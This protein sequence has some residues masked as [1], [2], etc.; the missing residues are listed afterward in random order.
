MHF[1]EKCWFFCEEAIILICWFTAN[2]GRHSNFENE[3]QD[4][5]W[6]DVGLNTFICFVRCFISYFRCHVLFSSLEFWDVL[7]N[8]GCESEVAELELVVIANKYVLKFYVQVCI[9][10]LCV[11]MFKCTT[12]LA[13][14][15]FEEIFVFDWSF[16]KNY[17]KQVSFA[18][19]HS[20]ITG[21]FLFCTTLT[22][23]CEGVIFVVRNFT[24]NLDLAILL[25]KAIC[26]QNIRVVVA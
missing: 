3:Q 8:P 7:I 19:F 4:S 15:V 12:N 21:I 2:K 17:I 25:D 14:E 26:F 11:E 13:E 1:P 18:Q 23:V 20:H 22:K 10:C 6:K 5:Q 9:R 24:R 16:F